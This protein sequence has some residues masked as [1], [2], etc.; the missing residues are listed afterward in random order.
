MLNSHPF[1]WDHDPVTPGSPEGTTSQHRSCVNPSHKQTYFSVSTSH[2]SQIHQENSKLS[3]YQPYSYV[4]YRLRE[5]PL[6]DGAHFKCI[7]VD[8]S[9]I[10]QNCQYGSKWID[11]REK[12]DKAK[13]LKQF[14]VIIKCSLWESREKFKNT[15]TA[16]ASEDDTTTWTTSV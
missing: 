6:K 12:T 3:T 16:H 7:R 5:R 15:F 10:V 2:S 8:F 11:A 1:F 4:C 9:D 13:L 14:Q